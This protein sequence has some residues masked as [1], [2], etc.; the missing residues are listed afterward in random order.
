M[1]ANY[2]KLLFDY[3]F[4]VIG[5][6]L[7]SPLLLIV[8]IGLAVLYKGSPFFTQT[9]PGRYNNLF[10]IYKFKTMTDSKDADGNLLPDALRLT[11]VGSLVRKTSLDELPQLFNVLRGELSFIGPRPLLPEYLPLYNDLQKRRHEVKPGISGWSQVNGRN[12][13]SWEEK[14]RL[15]VWY[16]DN[17]SFHLDLKILLL[18]MKK[19]YVRE[20]ISAQGHASMEFFNGNQDK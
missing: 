9:R 16:V 18:T 7:L 1:Y 10:T 3:I 15:D 8:T 20:G 6:I 4:A 5:L 19:V 11:K 12:A 2:I 13:I 17:I 14:L